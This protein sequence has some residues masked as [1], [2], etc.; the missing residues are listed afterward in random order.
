[1]PVPLL[2]H[3]KNGGWLRVTMR[4]H[5]GVITTSFHML[6]LSQKKL[7]LLIVVVVWI[8]LTFCWGLM[9]CFCDDSDEFTG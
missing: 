8:F 1:M 7:F 2:S 5:I 3:A 9:M 4:Q 6:A